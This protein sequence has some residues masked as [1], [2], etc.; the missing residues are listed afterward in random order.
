MSMKKKKERILSAIIA[1]SLLTT[2]V[3]TA[4]FMTVTAFADEAVKPYTITAPEIQEGGS[5]G[6]SLLKSAAEGT[7]VSFDLTVNEG[8]AVKGDVSYTYKDTAGK[9]IKT[10]LKGTPKD[11][12]TTT[13]SF[14]MPAA[15]VTISA[16]VLKQVSITITAPEKKENTLTVSQVEADENGSVTKVVKENLKTDDKLFKGD[17]I[18]VETESNFM[19]KDGVVTVGEGTQ[20]NSTNVYTVGDNNI[21]V[22]AKF[23][24]KAQ[25]AITITQPTPEGGAGED[26]VG[27][28]KVTADGVAVNNGDKILEGANVVLEYEQPANGTTVNVPKFTVEKADGDGEGNAPTLENNAFTMGKIPVKIS[29]TETE[30][31]KVG[32]TVTDPDSKQGTISVERFE[33]GEWI[34]YIY[35]SEQPSQDG[36]YK[37]ITKFKITSTASTGYQALEL[38]TTGLDPVEGEDNVYVIKSDADSVAIGAS[39]VKIPSPLVIADKEIVGGKVEVTKDGTNA[40]KDDVLDIVPTADEGYVLVKVTVNDKEIKAVDD[41]YTYTVTG[42]EKNNQIKVSA[43]F[44]PLANPAVT[45]YEP[46]KDSTGKPTGTIVVKNGET[47]LK[48]GDKVNEDETLTL[49]LTPAADYKIGD[50]PEGWTAVEGKTGEY[51]RKITKDDTAISV[52]HKFEALKKREVTY[53]APT[54]GNTAVLS[55]NG[56]VKTFDKDG[57]VDGKALV[58]TEGDKINIK[59]TPKADDYKCG[60]VD[61]FS[62]VKE[63]DGKTKKKDEFEFTVGADVDTALTIDLSADTVFVA[64]KKPHVT[65]S[66]KSVDNGK[67]TITVT[68]DDGT[69]LAEADGNV[70]ATEG[71]TLL[72]TVTPAYGSTLGDDGVKLSKG[73]TRVEMVEAAKAGKDDGAKLIKVDANTYKYTVQNSDDALAFEATFDAPTMSTFKFNTIKDGTVVIKNADSGIEYSDGDVIFEGDKFTVEAVGAEGYKPGTVTVGTLKAD[74]KGVYTV[75]K[76]LATIT[77]GATFVKKTAITVNIPDTKNGTVVVK[78][79]DTVVEPKGTV[80]EGEKL[81]ITPTP[82]E[83][84]KLNR[85]VATNGDLVENN[86]GTFTLTLNAASASAKQ[87]QISTYFQALAKADVKITNEAAKGEL[88]VNGMTALTDKVTEGDKLTIKAAAKEGYILT[89]IK[90]NDKAVDVKDGVAEYTVKAE[91]TVTVAAEYREAKKSTLTFAKPENGTIKVTKGEMPLATDS[92]VYEGD[93]LKIEAVADDKYALDGEIL[94]TGAVKNADGTYTVNKD[95]NPVTVEAAFVYVKATPAVT[96]ATATNGKFTVTNGDKAVASGDKVTEGDVLTITATANTNYKVGKVLV[97]GT[98]VTAVDGKYTYTVAREDVSI[99]VEFTY[100]KATPKVTLVAPKNGKYTVK[101]GTKTIANNGKVTE[102]QTLTITPT[103]NKYYKVSKV[104]VNGKAIAAKSGKYTYKATRAAIKVEVQFTYVKAT[105]KVTLVTAKNGK[106][107]VKVGNTTIKNGVTVTE[108]QTLTITP[109]A[110]KYYKVSKV[111]VNGKAITAKSG[112]YTYK[113]TRAAIKV[114]V[115]FAYVKATPKVTLAAAKNGKYTVKVGNKV[116]KNGNKVTEGQTLTIAP[117]AN[118]GYKVAKVVVNGKTIKPVKGKYT[119]KVTRAAVKITVTFAKK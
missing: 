7:Y 97:N 85:V 41:R 26:T 106:Y 55:V 44:R 31:G 95:G 68:Y 6:E 16:E 30:A 60:T 93:V 116:I 12:K 108:G 40:D 105:P 80:L 83:G 9:D 21:T 117:T 101:V 109:T 10:V 89:G 13:Y 111:L 107:T 58:V 102:G 51:T 37:G 15:N 46:A 49:I 70:T 32:V 78:N 112:K 71:K 14:T 18:L 8:Y 98:A 11:A 50:A 47:E 90:V 1:A 65:T 113:A 43:E 20:V 5:I 100:V 52:G 28:I 91:A 27:K 4:S 99:D 42:N 35:T 76:S 29:V 62:P 25:S 38:T 17:K 87:V 119:Y 23:E 118:K 92:T 103:A 74:D 67:G 82:A 48:S 114:E 22:S 66:E 56:V 88:T 24:A 45:I 79:G 63:A 33:N 104:L 110:N 72:F 59:L 53:T 77:V 86:D 84:Y 39:F 54:N 81:T 96:L 2:S 75:P 61:D 19:Y 3:N 34:P 36:N 57:K 94:V 69:A 73:G 115:Q 64:L